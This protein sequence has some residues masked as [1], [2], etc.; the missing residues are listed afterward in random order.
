M[1]SWEN[2]AFSLRK[3]GEHAEAGWLAQ[4]STRSFRDAWCVARAWRR[5][6]QR[7]VCV[8]VC[9]CVGRRRICLFVITATLAGEKV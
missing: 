8:C 2:G 6:A 4:R 1:E 7:S 9:V 5:V 3:L